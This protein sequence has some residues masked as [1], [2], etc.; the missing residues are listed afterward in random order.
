MFILFLL[1]LIVMFPF[2]FL[3]FYFIKISSKFCSKCACNFHDLYG[4]IYLMSLFFFPIP[5]VCLQVYHS[6]FLFL[7]HYFCSLCLP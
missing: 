1:S 6:L 2:D 4:I 5:F 7:L 3:A